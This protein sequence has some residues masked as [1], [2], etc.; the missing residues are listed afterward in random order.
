MKLHY[1]DF[2]PRLLQHVPL[3]YFGLVRYYGSY[4]NR[5]SIPKEY[6]YKA[7]D[8]QEPQESW[9]DLQVE[10]TG[11][12]PLLCSECKKPKVYLYTRVKIKRRNRIITFRRKVLVDNKLVKKK[13]A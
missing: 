2:F 12:N 5:A 1:R 4:S 13:T 9:E 6:L 3:K 7:T 8:E 10:K 11:I